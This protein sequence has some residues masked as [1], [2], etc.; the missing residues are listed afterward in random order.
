MT[1]PTIV[2]VVPV[3]GAPPELPR[4]VSALAAQVDHV[5]LVDDGSGTAA[6][7]RFGPG[8]EVVSLAE[9]S[10]IAAALN[11]A[12]EHARA[13][14]ATHVLTL[15]QDS[16]LDDGHVARLLAVLEA[17]EARGDRPAGAAPGVVGGARVLVGAGGEP[18]DPIQSG[19]LVP[20]RVFDELGGF[21][22][23]L[24]I[25]AVDSEFTVRARAAGYRYVMD[26]QLSMAHALGE[27]VPLQV[28]GRPLV[29][30][31]RQRHVLYHSP[32]RTYY[33]VRNSVWLSRRYGAGDRRWMRRRNRKMAE[34]VI[35]S[36]LL[37]PDRWAQLAAVRAGWRHGR[38]GALGRIPEDLQ[39][40]LRRRS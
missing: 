35:G 13:R 40:R 33:M 11:V 14:H 1:A 27:A 26:E 38:R 20:M 7:M 32:A 3:F 34:L 12:I 29:V 18:F 6:P 5:V 2:A 28:F 24:F 37:A 15:D 21:R 17:A 36:T 30:L 10:G 16:S 23:E 9:N 39:A 8:V 22:A 25:D 31:G 19:Q 4:T